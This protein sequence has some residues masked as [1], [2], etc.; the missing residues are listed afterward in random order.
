MQHMPQ[1]GLVPCADVQP[2]LDKLY[3]LHAACRT[4]GQHC[5]LDN[6]VPRAGVLTLLV[7]MIQEL[8]HFLQL[9]VVMYTVNCTIADND[10]CVANLSMIAKG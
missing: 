7:Y 6:I 1:A 10:D 9:Q 2:V 3:A 8:S 5:A 4:G